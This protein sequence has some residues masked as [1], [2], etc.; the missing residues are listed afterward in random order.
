MI[1]VWSSVGDLM[2][3]VWGLWRLNWFLLVL[4]SIY[5]LTRKGDWR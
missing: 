2:L 3:V 1:E 4:V 5:L